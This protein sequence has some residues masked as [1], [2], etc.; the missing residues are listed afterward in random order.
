M[1]L[2]WKASP[3]QKTWT[4][5]LDPKAKFADGSA[6]SAEAVEISFERLLKIGQGSAEAYPSDLK[7]EAVDAHTVRFTLSAPFAP[8]ANDGASIINPA[9]LSKHRADE[10]KG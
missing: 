2:S 4:F 7:V 1:A 9:L 3:D 8:L 5:K 6:V 10:G